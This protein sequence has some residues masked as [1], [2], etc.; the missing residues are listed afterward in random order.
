M[1]RRQVSSDLDALQQLHEQTGWT[2]G[3]EHIRPDPTSRA[4]KDLLLSN[5]NA[6]WATP[7]DWV[8]TSACTRGDGWSWHLD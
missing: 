1:L 6:M 3:R 7:A 4:Q 8:R 5:I 2:P